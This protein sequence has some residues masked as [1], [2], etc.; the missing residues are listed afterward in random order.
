MTGAAQM[1]IVRLPLEA[2]RQRGGHDRRSDRHQLALP[3]DGQ[4]RMSGPARSGRRAPVAGC[5]A[6]GGADG[7]E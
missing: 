1:L 2:R 6:D 4:P 5:S 7:G 3:H